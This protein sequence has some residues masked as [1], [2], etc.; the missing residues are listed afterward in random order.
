[1]I[2]ANRRSVLGSAV[3]GRIF[4]VVATLCVGVVGLLSFVVL[5]QTLA[6]QV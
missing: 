1:L 6:S 4:R 3:N 2:L 5:I